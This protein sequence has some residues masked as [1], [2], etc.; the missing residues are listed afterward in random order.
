M[1]TSATIQLKILVRVLDVIVWHFNSYSLRLE[2]PVPFTPSRLP[3]RLLSFFVS[4][5][6]ATR[7]IATCRN[8]PGRRKETRKRVTKQKEKVRKDPTCTSSWNAEIRDDQKENPKL[9]ITTVLGV[10]Y[11]VPCR[12]D[13]R[14]STVLQEYMALLCISFARATIAFTKS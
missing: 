10:D 3:I 12:R 4:S 9:T 6:S 8:V 2:S 5:S 11:Y 14:A 1:F 13:W 7:H